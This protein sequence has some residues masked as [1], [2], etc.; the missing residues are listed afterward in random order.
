MKSDKNDS[1]ML[2]LLGYYQVRMESKTQVEILD[3]SLH[4]NTLKKGIT[5]G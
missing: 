3:V 4:N 1:F 2:D 5:L